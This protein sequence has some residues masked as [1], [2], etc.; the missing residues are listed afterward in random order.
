MPTPAP[1]AKPGPANGRTARAASGPRPPADQS[2]R[3]PK[4][5]LVWLGIDRRP[6]QPVRKG[7]EPSLGQQQ[8]DQA[9]VQP[10][11]WNWPVWLQTPTY[12]ELVVMPMATYWSAPRWDKLRERKPSGE[13]TAIDTGTAS[14][15]QPCMPGGHPVVRTADGRLLARQPTVAGKPSAD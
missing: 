14:A 7:S 2:E 4:T 6:H 11:C 5:P 9:R 8:L 13:W 12:D 1:P 10:I 15:A 3:H